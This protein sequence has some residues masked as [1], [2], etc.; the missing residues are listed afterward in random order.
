MSNAQVES[1]VRIP[2]G[3]FRMGS[4]RHYPED[5]PVH[6]VAVNDF[7]IDAHTTSGFAAW[8]AGAQKR[9]NESRREREAP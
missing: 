3:A 4:D 1:M 5:S 7:W 2:G 9:S 8:C 6:P